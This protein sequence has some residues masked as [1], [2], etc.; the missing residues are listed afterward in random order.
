MHLIDADVYLND[1]SIIRMILPIVNENEVLVVSALKPHKSIINKG[2]VKFIYI[3]RNNR[4]RKKLSRYSS[5]VVGPST[6][7]KHDIIKKIGKFR[8]T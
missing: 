7:I 1:E 4:L 8:K 6:A 2:I 3:N 5:R